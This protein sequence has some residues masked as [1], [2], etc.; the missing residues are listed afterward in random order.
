MVHSW[1]MEYRKHKT[2]QVLI[3]SEHIHI[4][5]NNTAY[6][7]FVCYVSKVKKERRKK[8]VEQSSLDLSFILF[9]SF[10]SKLTFQI[11][12]E[13]G[14]KREKKKTRVRW[15]LSHCYSLKKTRDTLFSLLWI[16]EFFCFFVVDENY[17]KSGVWCD[18]FQFN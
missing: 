6:I 11:K 5:E 9:L 17:D 16:A 3:T 13:M 7:I 2:Q 4:Y 15:L 18:L 10:I 8:R 12:E 14:R 1:E